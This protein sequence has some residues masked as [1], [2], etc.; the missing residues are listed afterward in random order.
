MLRLGNI[1]SEYLTLNSIF[2]EIFLIEMP[3]RLYVNALIFFFF[4]LVCTNAAK[5]LEMLVDL[6][7]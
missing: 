2:E 6:F 4:P 3:E 7:R 5:C 1:C